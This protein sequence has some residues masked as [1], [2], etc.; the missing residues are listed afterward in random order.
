MTKMIQTKF[1]SLKKGEEGI[2]I[3]K[4]L[5]QRIKKI[6]NIDSTVDDVIEDILNHCDKCDQFWENRI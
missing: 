5:L 3:Q 4:K 2:G 6:G 1:L